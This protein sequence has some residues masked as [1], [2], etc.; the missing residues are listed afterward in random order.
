METRKRMLGSEHPDTLIS[1]NNL[2]F[3]FQAQGCKDE[4]ILLIE[5]CV[6]MQKK[7]LGPQHPYTKLSL[8]TLNT[9]QLE[10]IKIG[11]SS[12]RA[13]EGGRKAGGLSYED[14]FKGA[15][16]GASRHA[17]YESAPQASRQPHYVATPVRQT[18]YNASTT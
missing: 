9:W 14:E 1:M 4:A 13:V 18:L 15:W 16:F 6:Q 11:E 10:N 5:Q 12:R 2:A 8:T 7:V 17:D 3:T